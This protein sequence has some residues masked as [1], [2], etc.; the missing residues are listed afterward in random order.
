MWVVGPECGDGVIISVVE[1]CI[2]GRKQ[3]E[4]RYGGSLEED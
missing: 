3:Q 4:E 1:R 2:E